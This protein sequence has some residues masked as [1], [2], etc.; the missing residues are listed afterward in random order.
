MNVKFFIKTP[1]EGINSIHVRV[2]IGRSIDLSMVTKEVAH[3]NEWDE[4]NQCL[5]EEFKEFKKGKHITKRDAATKQKIRENTETN[6]RLQELKKTIESSYRS[7]KEKIDRDWLKQIIYPENFTDQKEQEEFLVYCDKFI[8]AK[9]KNIKKYYLTKINSIKEIIKRFLKHKK[10][11]RLLISEI[12]LLFKNE[13]EHYCLD[14]EKYSLNYFEGNFK[15]I[16][17]ILNHAKQ[18]GYPVFQGLSSIKCSVEK[19][20]FVILSPSEIEKISNLTLEDE[21]LQTARDWLLISCFSGQRV[22]DFMNFNTNMIT[23]REVNNQKRYFIEFIQEKTKKQVF[24]P[25]D[26]RIIEIIEKRNWNFPRKMSKPRYNEHI[27]TVC[28]VAGIDEITEGTLALKNDDDN[29]KDRKKNNRRKV[30]G[31]M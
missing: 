16:K 12:N 28:R 24:L 11:K 10:R 31:K 2:R 29:I 15:F 9:G 7:S 14:I 3:F 1:K 30:Y 21:H 5:L 23:E 22:S 18:N 27:K 20:S 13:F 8:E 26:S 6:Y 19:T 25:L 4:K 17:T